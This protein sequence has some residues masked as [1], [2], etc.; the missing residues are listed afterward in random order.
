MLALNRD[1]GISFLVVTHDIA[2]ARR[3]DRVLQLTDGVLS[4][5]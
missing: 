5:G 3:M 4:P 1:I 2:L